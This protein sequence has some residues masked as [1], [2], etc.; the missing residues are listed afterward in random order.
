MSFS[1]PQNY[2][3]KSKY[4]LLAKG[5]SHSFVQKELYTG[6]SSQNL[7]DI[8]QS[9]KLAGTVASVKYS[10]LTVS[11]EQNLTFKRQILQMKRE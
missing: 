3:A 4:I 9:L 11:T 5:E 2:K 6:T 7:R 10:F 8:S 1:K